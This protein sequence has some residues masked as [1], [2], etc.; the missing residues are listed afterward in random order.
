MP[1]EVRQAVAHDCLGGADARSLL[2]LP[3]TAPQYRALQADV[4][5]SL[6]RLLDIPPRFRL[7]FLPGGATAQF[8]AVPLNLLPPAGRAAYVVTGHWSRRAAEEA[9]SHG[10]IE[11]IGPEAMA[12]AEG[13]AY[14]HITTNETADGCQYRAWPEVDAPLVAD[15]TSDLLTRPIDFSRLALGYAATQKTIGVPGLTVVIVREDLLGRARAY[16]PR[17]LDYTRQAEADSRLNTP[18]VFPM[19]VARHMLDW[20]EAT[21]GVAAVAERIERH[22]AAVY[23]ALEA[24][25]GR[26]RVPVTP[27]WRS[28][29][30]PCFQLAEP[31][32]TEHF[33]AAAADAGL[34]ELRGHPR[35]GGV[36]VSLYPG[37]ETAAV[38]ALVGFIRAFAAA[39]T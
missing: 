32:H 7:L 31:A 22:G 6:R 29:V 1:V 23:G 34:H 16:T 13:A 20:I 27:A 11:R 12:R 18:P 38:D 15:M 35:S 2:S 9:A 21:G 5:A 25:P 39:G 37:L 30:N 4:D 10:R 28:R 36:R 14:V 17:V 8:A 19:G 33:L 26:Y 24:S 3:F